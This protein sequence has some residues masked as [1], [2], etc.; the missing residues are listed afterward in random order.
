MRDGLVR[1]AQLHVRSSQVVVRAGVLGI[2]ANGI[3]Q[4]L[5]ALPNASE[6]DEQAPQRV[7][8]IN[9]AGI[10]PDGLGQPGQ[11]LFRWGTTWRRHKLYTDLD[12]VRSELNLEQAS[13]MAQPGFAAGILVYDFRVP[14]DS[15]AVQMGC[16]PRGDVPGV[17]M[18]I[19]K[20]PTP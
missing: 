18:G 20:T 3:H 12:A 5:D 1:L 11:G 10:D 16:Y 17:R 15:P 9:V 19:R 2:E 6:L 14:A 13:R 7:E 4:P 8:R